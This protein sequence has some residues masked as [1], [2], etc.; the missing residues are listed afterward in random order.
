MKKLL[1]VLARGGILAY[2]NPALPYKAKPI[3]RLSKS[4]SGFHR[5]SAKKPAFNVHRKLASGLDSSTNVRLS[6]SDNPPRIDTASP[7]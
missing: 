4:F 7:E 5:V 3:F 2:D 6:T 1:H